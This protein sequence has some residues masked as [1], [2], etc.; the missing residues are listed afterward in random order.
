[1]QAKFK[2]EN[3]QNYSPNIDNLRN[4]HIKYKN[5]NTSKDSMNEGGLFEDD[6]EI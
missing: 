2:G 6:S 4:S 1:M 5:Q 3:G